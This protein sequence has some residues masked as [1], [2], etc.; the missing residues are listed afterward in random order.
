MEAKRVLLDIAWLV[1]K[2]QGRSSGALF[3]QRQVYGAGGQ[4]LTSPLVEL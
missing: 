2:G 4:S 1:G 3:H